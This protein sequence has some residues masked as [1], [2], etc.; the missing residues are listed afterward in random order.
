MI[1]ERL[2]ERDESG[3]MVRMIER[4]L[5]VEE[6][7]WALVREKLQRPDVRALERADVTIGPP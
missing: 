7:V 3:R 2:V 6:E 5:P 4:Q 1:G